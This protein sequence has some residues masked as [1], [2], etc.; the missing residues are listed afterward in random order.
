MLH[1]LALGYLDVLGLGSLSLG[2]LSLGLLNFWLLSLGLL[3]LGLLGLE[4]LSHEL[5]GFR[6]VSLRLL[7]FKFF[8]L[9]LH[10]LGLLS[11]GL[12][13]LSH[14]ALLVQDNEADQI[15]G[16]AVKYGRKESLPENHSVLDLRKGNVEQVG[17][18]E[19][20][21]LGYVSQYIHRVQLVSEDG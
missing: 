1:P 16:E 15:A 6:F 9:R 14:Q 20:L 2:S 18:C 13:S 12:L 11:L 17:T 5:L 3:S 7:R 8:S 19:E 10:H 4:L 21:G